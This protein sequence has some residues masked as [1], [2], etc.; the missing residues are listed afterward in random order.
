MP[1]RVGLSGM[2][3]LVPAL[4][5]GY[6]F[7]RPAFDSIDAQLMFEVGK[8]M[9]T[10][11]TTSVPAA[12]DPFH[13]QSPHPSY[14]LGMS[15][16]MAGTYTVGGWTGRNPQALAMLVNPA[17]FV[18]LAL[19]LW[20]WALAAG[21]SSARAAL[22]AL[23]TAFGALLLP[24]VPTGLSELG[25]ALGV[26]LCL[27]GVE[28]AGRSIVASGLVA[29][30]G[31]S[32]AVLMRPDSVLLVA[33]PVAIA[34]A[35]HARRAT[36]FYLLGLAPSAIV[37]GVYNLGGGSRY[38]GISLRHAFNHPFWDGVSGL[39]ISPGRGLLL[40]APLT[41]LALAAVPWAWRR[42]HAMVILCLVLLFGRVAF[43]APWFAWT[44]GWAWGP[45]FLVPGMPAL[46]PLLAEPIRHISWR[47][48]YVM[49]VVA[50]ILALSVSVQLLGAAIRYDTD[51]DNLAMTAVALCTPEMGIDCV[52]FATSRPVE[53]AADGVLFD[54]R[55]FP[56][57]EHAK[58]V[59]GG[60][61]LVNQRLT[62][63]RAGLLSI[64]FP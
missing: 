15:I 13:Q 32:L 25:A 22:V 12:L 42:S 24:Y 2:T 45:R 30:A 58:K 23:T 53:A 11:H 8:S 4:L 62:A 38:A 10:T 63:V 39:L 48:S 31:S 16:L 40:Y 46:V 28:L 27:I 14:G 52:A 21:L 18:A 37:T 33:L 20:A 54:W 55:Y 26:A 29:G 3:V 1:L 44:G 49:P 17:L 47:R 51:T 41:I 35:L 61:D 19:A 5:A 59:R 36:L 60:Q 6:F 64:G 34:L 9:I 7:A 56:I 57:P 43:F 50:P